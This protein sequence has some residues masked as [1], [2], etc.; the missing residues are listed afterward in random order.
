MI[1]GHNRIQISDS[2]VKL[3]SNGSTKRKILSKIFQLVK[4]MCTCRSMPLTL[5]FAFYKRNDKFSLFPFFGDDWSDW[6]I[7]RE[8]HYCQIESVRLCAHMCVYAFFFLYKCHY[9]YECVLLEA[10]NVSGILIVLN[11]LAKY[12]LCV[13]V[14]CCVCVSYIQIAFIHLYEMIVNWWWG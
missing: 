10:R 2:Y 7:L 5:T 12:C 8:Y 14:C 3:C 4:H 11:Y 1:C 6:N 9:C 13:C